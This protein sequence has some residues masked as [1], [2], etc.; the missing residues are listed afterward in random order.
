LGAYLGQ[1]FLFSITSLSTVTVFFIFYFIARDAI[2]FFQLKGL[3][4]FFTSTHWYPSGHP[5]EF[6]ALA[7]FF[8]TALVT[9]GAV[10]VAVPLGVSAA[11][12]WRT[13]SLRWLFLHRCCRTTA[14]WCWLQE[15]D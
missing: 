1:G 8:G 6:G 7:V 10:L 12:L 5:A 15:P 3:H 4:E 11:V 13:D 14:E 9:L 2:P